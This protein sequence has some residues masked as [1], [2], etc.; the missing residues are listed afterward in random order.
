L[1]RGDLHPFH[2]PTFKGTVRAAA[3]TVKKTRLWCQ[4]IM[5]VFFQIVLTQKPVLLNI[6]LI[7]IKNEIEEFTFPGFIWLGNTLI[8]PEFLVTYLF[9]HKEVVQRR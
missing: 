5:T 7:L 9:D 8:D 4:A 3:F 2:I 6:L 1:A